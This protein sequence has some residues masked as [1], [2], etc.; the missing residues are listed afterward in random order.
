MFLIESP[1]NFN[2]EFDVQK[3][4]SCNPNVDFLDVECFW[5]SP[6]MTEGPACNVIFPRVSPPSCVAPI[7]SS[8]ISAP[9]ETRTDDGA[10]ERI[11]HPH[12][13]DCTD[14]RETSEAKISPVVR[15]P[16]N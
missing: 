10:S 5:T 11:T 16:I 13:H 9:G 14:E 3:R 4:H 8:A 1:K 2:H 15:S 7:F 6:F 12:H